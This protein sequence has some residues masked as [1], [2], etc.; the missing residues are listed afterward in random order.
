MGNLD[1]AI[2]INGRC[3]VIKGT[4]YLSVWEAIQKATLRWIDSIKK[5]WDAVKDDTNVDKT[6]HYWDAEPTRIKVYEI[7]TY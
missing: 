3:I 6:D 5:E 7:S 4:D 2:I 1:L